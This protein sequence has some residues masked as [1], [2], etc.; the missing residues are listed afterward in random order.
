MA[1][2][3][4]LRPGETFALPLQGRGSSGYSWS[5][6]ISGNRDAVEVRIQGPPGPPRPSGGAAPSSGS[7][8]EELIVKGISPGEVTVHL[9]LRRS[10]E[11]DKPPLA[12][13][14]L[15]VVVHPQSG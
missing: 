3:V 15:L 9:A 6:E 4:E 11:R 10:W 2:H 13:E 8:D 14:T 12:E 5:Y 1:R 7:A